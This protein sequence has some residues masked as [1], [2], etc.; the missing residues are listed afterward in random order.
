MNAKVGKPWTLADQ[1]TRLQATPSASAI[2]SFQAVT[3]GSQECLMRR[4]WF[5]CFGERQSAAASA[6]FTAFEASGSRRVH[7]LDDVDKK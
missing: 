6:T 3:F 4:V 2:S 7:R 1:A 5:Y